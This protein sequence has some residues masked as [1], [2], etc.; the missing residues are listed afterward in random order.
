M[1][2]RGDFGD[3]RVLVFGFMQE[4]SLILSGILEISTVKKVRWALP[5][6]LTYV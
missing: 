4:V 2:I 6:L 1:Q 3:R 5:T